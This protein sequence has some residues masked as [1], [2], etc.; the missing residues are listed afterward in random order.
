MVVA[1]ADMD[2]GDQLAAFAAHDQRKLGVGLQLDEA[3]DDLYAGAFQ[4]ARP[5]DIGLFV[6]A[7]LEFDQR[8]D[9]LAGFGGLGKRLMIGESAEVR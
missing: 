4:V 9:R 7:R 8:G 2:V 3:I 5:A 6:E 1:G